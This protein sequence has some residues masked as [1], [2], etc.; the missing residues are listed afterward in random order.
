[1]TPIIKR[2]ELAEAALAKNGF[3]LVDDVWVAS[4]SGRDAALVDV[5]VEAGREYGNSEL[6][7]GTIEELL[8]AHPANGAQAG[9]KGTCP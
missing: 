3:V 6:L 5:L 9:K 4:D 7:R 8:A 2:L 1:M